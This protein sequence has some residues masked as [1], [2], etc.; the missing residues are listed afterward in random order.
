MTTLTNLTFHIQLICLF[1]SKVHRRQHYLCSFQF[2]WSPTKKREAHCTMPLF[3]FAQIAIEMRKRLLWPTSIQKF[4]WPKETNLNF[5]LK[6][7]RCTTIFT[8]SRLFSTQEVDNQS[9]NFLG[10]V[11]FYFP[12]PQTF[13]HISALDNLLLNCI[14][15]KHIICIFLIRCIS[16]ICCIAK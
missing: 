7:K 16:R 6:A 9:C 13:H 11:F 12:G 4:Q 14:P 10:Q 8:Q 1:S 2:F 15:E 5:S 3:K